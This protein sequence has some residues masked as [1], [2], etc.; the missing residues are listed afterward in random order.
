MEKLETLKNVVDNAII[1]SMC[2]VGKVETKK[3]T[4][5]FGRIRTTSLLCSS[6]G[7]YVTC[8]AEKKKL[9]KNYNE[10]KKNLKIG[11]EVYLKGSMSSKSKIFYVTFASQNVFRMELNHLEE[12]SENKVFKYIY[13]GD[14]NS[15]IDLIKKCW[16]SFNIN[17]EYGGRILIYSALSEKMG[18]LCEAI[19][20]HPKFDYSIE[21][22]FGDTIFHASLH[23]YGSNDADEKYL[24]FIKKVLD[25]ILSLKNIEFFNIKTISNET[26]LDIACMYPNEIWVVKELVSNP[27]VNINVIDDLNSTALTNA[28]RNKNIEAIKILSKRNDILVRTVD[29]EE[30]DKVGIDLADFGFEIAEKLKKAYEYAMA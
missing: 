21:D 23:L 9:G 4:N 14:E 3:E 10:I 15:A 30:A 19:I 24:K 28:I 18:D 5:S 7:H 20:K 6:D 13:D 29:L 11:R 16:D 22:G 17:Y 12:T 27:S 2:V 26:A 25:A 1:G 8:V